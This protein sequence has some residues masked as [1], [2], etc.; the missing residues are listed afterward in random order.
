MTK[1]AQDAFS[2]MAGKTNLLIG[3]EYA[4]WL[5]VDVTKSTEERDNLHFMRTDLQSG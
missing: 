5:P 4:K 3:Y 1:Q 2:Q